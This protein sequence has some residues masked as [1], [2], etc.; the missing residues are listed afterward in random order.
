MEQRPP[1]LNKD[2][3]RS[4][5]EMTHEEDDQSFGGD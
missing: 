1:I 3:L 5:G 4:H 2:G